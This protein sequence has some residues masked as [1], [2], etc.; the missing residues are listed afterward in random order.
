MSTKDLAKNL[1]L[2]KLVKSFL[3]PILEVHELFKEAHGERTNFL[4]MAER[5]EILEDPKIDR[6]ETIGFSSVSI[7]SK[8]KYSTFVP[9]HLQLYYFGDAKSR[10]QY[11]E[12]CES[13]IGENAFQILE[14]RN[15]NYDR[16]ELKD[17]L[18]MYNCKEMAFSVGT[19]IQGPYSIGDLI[20]GINNVAHC[21]LDISNIGVD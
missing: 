18:D 17:I 13:N 9:I 2:M 16:E 14:K 3:G 8:L 20:S 12:V 4:S 21:C 15:V 11:V 6:I 7:K 5:Q 1:T 19:R 10:E